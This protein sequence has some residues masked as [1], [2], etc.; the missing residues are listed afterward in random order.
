MVRDAE[1]GM[2]IGTR[3]S[4]VRFLIRFVLYLAVVV[5]GV[6]N[7]LSPLWDARRQSF[8]DKVA[9]SVVVRR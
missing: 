7:D 4:F 3:R 5:P 6:V 8:A 2:P 1:S 9:K